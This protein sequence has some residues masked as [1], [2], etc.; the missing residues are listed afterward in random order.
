MAHRFVVSFTRWDTPPGLDHI[1]DILHSARM[2]QCNIKMGFE[3]LS[4][5]V[6]LV[7]A[8]TKDDYSHRA[9]LTVTSR[10]D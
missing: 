8:V 2:V 10:P 7:D 1:R 6:K 4:D 5:A 9:I 3:N